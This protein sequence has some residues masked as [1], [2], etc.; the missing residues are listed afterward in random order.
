MIFQALNCFLY[1][2]YFIDHLFQ[3]STIFD[4]KYTIPVNNT[5]Y[6]APRDLIITF[7]LAL[8]SNRNR[9]LIG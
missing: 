4:K 8:I 7:I 2:L 3:D 6:I 9:G 5:Q 1:Y